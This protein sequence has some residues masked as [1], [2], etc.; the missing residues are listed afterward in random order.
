MRKREKHKF[1]MPESSVSQPSHVIAVNHQEQFS[2]PIPHPSLLQKY[3]EIVP[4]A[5]ERILVMGEQQSKHRM[6]LEKDVIE[7][8][9]K[10]S[11]QGQKY[12]FRIAILGLV[13]A[14]WLGSSGYEVASAAIGG[15]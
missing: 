15:G 10:K 1:F 6:E 11:E 13:I 8:D 3:N 14:A 9:I 12:A 5:A 7:S 2:G 4:G